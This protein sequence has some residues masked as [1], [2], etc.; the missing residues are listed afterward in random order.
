MVTRKKILDSP[1]YSVSQDGQVWNENTG[2]S[3]K[4]F[5]AGKYYAVKIHGKNRYIHKLVAD[6][7]VPGK[8][9]GAELNHKDE[10]KRNNSADN[11]EWVTHSENCNCG[12]RNKRA[13]EKHRKPIEAFK[14]GVSQAKY[15]SLSA[16]AKAT[17][18]CIATIGKVACGI[19]KTAGGYEWRYIA[20]GW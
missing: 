18:I 8:F 2:L 19:G 7:F 17:G 10:D 14:N 9:D 15:P 12:T 5:L 3:L 16:A 1:E 20:E 13:G 6:L 11:L 4:P